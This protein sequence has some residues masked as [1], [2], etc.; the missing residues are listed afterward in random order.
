MLSFVTSN[1]STHMIQSNFNAY[2]VLFLFSLLFSLLFFMQCQDSKLREGISGFK[3]F[4]NITIA[5]SDEGDGPA[6]ILLHG[7]INNADSWRKT[8]LKQDLLDKGFR[9][10]IPDLR[11]NGDSDKPQ[12]PESYMDNAEVKD[13]Q[14]L[15]DHLD[16][17]EYT[18][19][20]YSRGSI[21]L[22]K[23]LTMD[24]RISKA[25]LGG[26]GLDFTIKE[27]DRRLAF[28]D[29]FSG[30]ASLSPLTEGAVNYAKSIDADLKI[31]GHLQDF[32]PHTSVEAL[33]AISSDV[34]VV[35]GD[36]DRDNGDP[37]AL[38]RAFANAQ[39]SIVS[40]DHNNTYKQKNFSKVV[41]RFLDK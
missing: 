35:A 15:A 22:A 39:I 26:M 28:A 9:V 13:I 25:V 7:F 11:G 37:S 23:L 38:F 2:S 4:D 3:S 30:R 33:G 10:I 16:L 19:I 8:V 31:L 21:V 17:N 36:E 34:L 40:G 1:H 41:L 5:Y 27:W 20:G 29:A 32:Q 12:D 6:V 24:K 18:A 14:A